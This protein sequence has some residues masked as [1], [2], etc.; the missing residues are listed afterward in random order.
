MEVIE[1]AAQ[2]DMMVVGFRGVSCISG[3]EQ[4]LEGARAKRAVSPSSS[5]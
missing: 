2:C 3:K 4:Q 5:F 1:T